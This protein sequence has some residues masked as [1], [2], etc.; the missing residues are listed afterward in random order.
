MG[1][2][3]YCRVSTVEQAREG[4]S[5]AEQERRCRA[6]ADL[7]DLSIVD[8][9]VDAGVSAK[10]LR[11]PGAELM[12]ERLSGD[13]VDGVVVWKLDRLLRSVSDMVRL[14]DLFEREG[15]TFHSVT[16]R[17]DTSD[18]MGL[19]VVHLMGAL[20]QL[21]RGKTCERV[22]MVVDATRAQGF[23]HGKA[24]FGYR[25]VPHDGAGSLLRPEAWLSEA[26]C[27]ADRMRLRGGTLGAIGAVLESRYGVPS[28]GHP[29][30]VKRLLAT[31]APSS[32]VYHKDADAYSYPVE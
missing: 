27:I 2:I 32:L 28:I 23:H 22:Q 6:Y 9:I 5:L 13:D 26:R 21:E 17:L 14:L 1:V 3:V 20:A 15:V 25:L 30:S 18:S 29:Q 31:P 16:E 11:R 19:F 4:L 12:M 24:P 8:V 10:D 7:F